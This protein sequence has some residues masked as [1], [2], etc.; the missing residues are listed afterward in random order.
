MTLIEKYQAATLQIE[1]FKK[2]CESILQE[3]ADQNCP[4]KIGDTVEILEYPYKGKTG[5]VKTILGR[6]GSWNN[7]FYWIVQGNLLK[8]DGK[9]G[10][11][12]F[13]FTQSDHEKWIK[14]EGGK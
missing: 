6:Y 7:K 13:S 3:Y 9:E 10:L 4:F 8:K 2:V 1:E 14:K 11:Q 5:V 12:D